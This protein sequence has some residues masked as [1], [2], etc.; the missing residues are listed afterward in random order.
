L[1]DAERYQTVYADALGSAAAPTAGLH[2]TERLFDQLHERGVSTV[3]VTLHVGLDTFQPVTETNV[4]EHRIHAEWFRVGAEARREIAR[5]KREGR[6][7]IAVGT[8]SVRVLESLARHAHVGEN[9]DVEGWTRLYITPGFRFQL[10]DAMITNFHLPRSTLLLL[11]YAFAGEGLT[12]AAY[13]HAIEHGYR[14]Y[15]FGDASLIV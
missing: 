4:L 3:R 9:E 2:F 15:S 12:R 5:V 13:A 10:V 8:T 1:D 7:V 11:V 6:R 14:F